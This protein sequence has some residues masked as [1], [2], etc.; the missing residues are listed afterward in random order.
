MRRISGLEDE[1]L[2][3]GTLK[4]LRTYKDGETLRNDTDFAHVT[5]VSVRM[6]LGFKYRLRANARTCFGH[7]GG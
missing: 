2:P 7:L 3:A 1:A 5:A 4:P 6:V